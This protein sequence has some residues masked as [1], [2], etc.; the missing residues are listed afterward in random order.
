MIGTPQKKI[1]A[2]ASMFACTHGMQWTRV[3]CL[4]W[5]VKG[6]GLVG[7]HIYVDF[8]YVKGVFCLQSEKIPGKK[9]GKRALLR[10][11]KRS[12]IAEA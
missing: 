12:K 8:A 9:K 6:G 7:A 5:G 10:T 3:V 4:C 11:Q 1:Q 2:I